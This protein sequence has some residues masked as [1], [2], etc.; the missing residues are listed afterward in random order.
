MD[1]GFIALLG[2]QYTAISLIDVVGNQYTAIS[3]IGVVGMVSDV[4]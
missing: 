4:G 2:N 1:T 3:L